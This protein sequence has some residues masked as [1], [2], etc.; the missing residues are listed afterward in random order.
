MKGSEGVICTVM[1]AAQIKK[2]TKFSS[3]IRNSDGIGCKIIYEEGL[4]D[5]LEMRR[6]FSKY[7]DAV[8]HI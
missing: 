1:D 3:Y 5:I 7:G 4:P 2:K 8:S 6:Y